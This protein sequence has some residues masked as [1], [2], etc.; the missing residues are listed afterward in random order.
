MHTHKN[1]TDVKKAQ[2]PTPYY[3][4]FVKGLQTLDGFEEPF[5]IVD[6]NLTATVEDI[7]ALALQLKPEFIVIDGAY[8]LKHP[9]R[10]LNRWDRV[11]ENAELMKQ[12]LATDLNIPVF[13]SWQLNREAAKKAKKGQETGLED[14]GYSDA[15]GQISSIVLALDEEDSV[16]TLKQR[17]VSVKKGRNGEVGSYYINWD[18]HNMNFSQIIESVLDEDGNYTTKH[19]DP[20]KSPLK[21]I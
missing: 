11:A 20:M 4:Q 17:K 2:L 10:R 15:I 12:A 14:I 9:N 5:W 16:E 21:F 19:A 8:L 1:L 6:G 18:F 7:W 3:K 13:A